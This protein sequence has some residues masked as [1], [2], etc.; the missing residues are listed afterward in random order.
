M[1]NIA[2]KPFGNHQDQNYLLTVSHNGSIYENI[3]NPSVFNSEWIEI[4][5]LEKVLLEGTGQTTT[6]LNE[7]LEIYTL[8]EENSSEKYLNI[9]ID[10]N[11][12][13]GKLK[14]KNEKITLRL[15]KLLK[16]TSIKSEQDDNIQL[17]PEIM[18]EDKDSLQTQIAD[19]KRY[20]ESYQAQI[21]DLN[22]DKDSLQTQFADLKRCVESYQAQI[23]HLKL[24]NDSLQA[25]TTDLKLDND[26]LRCKIQDMTQHYASFKEQ[27]TKI[28]ANIKK[29]E[30][31]QLTHMKRIKYG[32][33]VDENKILLIDRDKKVVLIYKKVFHGYG[34][35][36]YKEQYENFGCKNKMEE[37]IWQVHS[38]RNDKFLDF[39]CAY[40]KTPNAEA[41]K[42]NQIEAI[43]LVEEWFKNNKIFDIVLTYIVNS[44]TVQSLQI[45]ELTSSM[46]RISFCIKETRKTLNFHEP[47]KLRYRFIPGD[48]PPIQSKLLGKFRLPSTQN[49]WENFCFVDTEEKK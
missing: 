18:Q 16:T 7:N 11:L 49:T 8:F 6:K 24:D 42:S 40:M 29:C 12:K 4:E 41:V 36:F 23:T 47:E 34:H 37:I 15:P 22:L 33:N 10:A 20:V 19:L 17:A 5:D 38:Q 1:A 31:D 13:V 35:K 45:S 9:T 44:N 43:K 25:Q 30:A 2:Y 3:V 39:A 27:I 21:T 14:R 26:S 46:A 48:I 28:S 32:S